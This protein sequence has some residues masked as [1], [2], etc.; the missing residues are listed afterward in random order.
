MLT[1]DD[2]QSNALAFA[3]RWKDAKNEKSEAQMFVRYFLSIFGIDDAAAV[4]RFENPALKEEG[5]GFMDYFL[6]KKIA[7]EMK[8]QGKDL[9]EAYKQ[10]KDYIVHLPADEMPELLMV[11]DFETIV[12]YNRTTGKRTLF[13]TKDL[14]KHVKRF[15]VLAGYATQRDQ[16]REDQLEVNIRAAERMA[17]LHDELLEHGYEGHDLEIYLTRLLFCLFAGDTGIFPKDNFYDY[18]V[19]S[20][21]DGSDLSHRITDLFEVLNMPE[22]FRAK[23]KLLSEELKQFRYINGTLFQKILPKAR[24]NAKMRKL[25]LE[26]RSFDWSSISPAIFGAMFQGVMSKKLRREL[27]AH[28]TSEENILKLINPL[29]LDELWKEFERVK[30]DTKL[31]NQFHD[32]IAKLKFLDPACGCGNFLIVTYRE[33]RLL[34]IAILKMLVGRTRQKRLDIST[35]MKINIEQFY[36]IEIEDFPCQV[37]TVGMWLV[38]HQMNLRVGEECGQYHP[39]L[40]LT[41]CATIIHGNAHRLNWETIVPKNDLS[42]ILGNPPFVGKK[43]QS[44]VQK[45][46][47][48]STFGSKFKCVGNMDYVTAWYKRATDYMRDTAIKCAFVSTNSLAQGEQVELL[49]KPLTEKGV[50][51]NFGIPTFKW[52]NEAKGKAAVHC[53][54]VGFSYQKTEPH[55][56]PYLI[57]APTV[58]IESRSKPICNVPELFYGSMPIDY[59]AL[60]LSEEEMKALIKSEPTSKK[61][62]RRYIGGEELLN[63]TVRYCLWLSGFAPHEVLASD[64]VKER[65]EQCRKF[66]K[67]SN[68]PQTKIL[69]DTPH[70]FGRPQEKVLPQKGTNVLVIPKV[71][72]E[73]RKYLPLGFLPSEF[74][75]NG[76]ALAIPNATLYHFGILTSNVHNAWIRAVCGRLEMRYQYSAYIVYNNCPWMDATDDQ[77]ETIGKLAQ[78]VLDARAKFPGSSLASLY[79]LMPKELLKAHQALDR[80]VMKLYKF[81]PDMSESAIVAKLMEMYQKLTAPPTMIPEEETKK[82]RQRRS[83]M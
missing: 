78:A 4:G 30:T 60:I 56:N 68:R 28:Y 22:E 40:P 27:G 75:I 52:W 35:L 20:K 62:V 48:I 51:I 67:E 21:E 29:F 81:K 41:Q 12:H 47:M 33:L 37:A 17:L 79:N 31:L 80:A 18:I 53:V 7:I 2:I 49:W 1:W 38:D 26:C 3:I 34:E 25:L 73:N 23:Q 5:R 13:K 63:N 65:V 71:S 69:S 77:K 59:G 9:N 74:V 24:F 8:S 50:F 83:K 61:F 57:E 36:G 43:E 46:D 45:E 16:E 39:R 82:K 32:K 70:L 64:F 66:R 55:I 19:N 6:P 72:S 14:H 76:S 15:A 44:V 54:I 58:F 11:S 42:Y 10:L